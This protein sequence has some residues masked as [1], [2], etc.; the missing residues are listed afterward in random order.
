[1]PWQ[2][3]S[4]LIIIFFL[5]KCLVLPYFTHFF[6]FHQAL[7]FSGNCNESYFSSIFG[8]KHNKVRAI[9]T[10]MLYTLIIHLDTSYAFDMACETNIIIT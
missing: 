3:K 4:I 10:S 8:N 5:L 6:E 9:P 1:M 7:Q 2:M